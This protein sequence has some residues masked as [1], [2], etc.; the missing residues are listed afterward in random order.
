MIKRY[1]ERNCSAQNV[2]CKRTVE[3]VPVEDGLAMTPAQMNQLMQQGIPIASANL[4]LQY[5]EGVSELDFEPPLEH[6]R[7]IDINDMYESRQHIRKKF[8]EKLRDYRAKNVDV[9][10]E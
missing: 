9:N 2:T 8:A 1:L 6:R 7:G 5:E 4:G 10:P 3:D